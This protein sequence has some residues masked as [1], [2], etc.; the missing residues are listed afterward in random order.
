MMFTISWFSY[1]ISDQFD[2]FSIHL[3]ALNFSELVLQQETI[4]LRQRYSRAMSARNI[5]CGGKNEAIENPNVVIATDWNCWFPYNEWTPTILTFELS[6]IAW[7]RRSKPM[8]FS[9]KFITWESKT[10]SKVYDMN[11]SGFIKRKSKPWMKQHRSHVLNI[12]VGENHTR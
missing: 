1:F 7:V 11:N 5:F 8:K 4:I 12:H 2:V 3:I 6:Q 9:N 10:W